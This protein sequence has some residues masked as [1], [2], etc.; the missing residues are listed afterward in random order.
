MVMKTFT[1]TINTEWEIEILIKD[2]PYAHESETIETTSCSH[3]L[4]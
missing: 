3:I 2:V 1:K 4:W